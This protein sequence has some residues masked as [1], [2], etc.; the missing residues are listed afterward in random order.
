M[1]QQF[2]ITSGAVVVNSENQILLKKDPK[3]GWE[4]PGGLVESNETFKETVIREVKEE[5]G[6]EIEIVKFCGVSQ[7]VEKGICNMWWMGTPISGEIQTGLESIEVGYFE[8]EDALHLIKNE[9]FK[10]E[11]V[12]CLNENT[13][14]FFI[15]FQ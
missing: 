3:R 14:S 5:T 2:S 15:S 1:A 6:I 12:H 9:D 7:E 4:L 13:E 8:L 11:L 10:Q